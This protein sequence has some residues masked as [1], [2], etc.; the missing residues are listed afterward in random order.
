MAFDPFSSGRATPV[1]VQQPAD[2]VKEFD[3]FASGTAIETKPNYET[4]KQDTFYALD[5]DK[6]AYA[7]KTASYYGNL[8]DVENRLDNDK[9]KAMQSLIASAPVD[10]KREYTARSINQWFVGSQMPDMDP[11]WISDNWEGAKQAFAKTRL[12][13]D[14]EKI[15]DETLY[16]SVSR[17]LKEGTLDPKKPFRWHVP[18]EIFPLQDAE[19]AAHQSFWDSINNANIKLDRAPNNLPDVE[20]PYGPLG[21]PAVVAAI[22]NGAVAPFIE[23]L[24]SPIG[25]LTLGVVPELKLA[26]K[27]SVLAKSALLSLE[28][29]FTAMMGHATYNNVKEFKKL[30]DNPNSTTQDII[31]KGSELFLSSAGTIAAPL[32]L[33]FESLGSKADSI[34]AEMADKKPSAAADVLRKEAATAKDPA[35][36]ASVDNAAQSLED[37]SKFENGPASWPVAQEVPQAEFDFPDVTEEARNQVPTEPVIAPV[38]AYNETSLKNAV[39]ELERA[40]ETGEGFTETEKRVMAPQWIKSG[41]ILEK[42]PEAGEEL[43]ARL[44]KDP[45]IGLSDIQSAILLRYKLDIEAKKTK[46][47]DLFND[48]SQPA[49]VREAAFTRLQ[50]AIAEKVQ[51]LD[52][53]KAR[54]SEWGR[55]G[56]WRQAV[57]KEDYSFS[58]QSALLQ[59][60]KGGVEL[61]ESEITDLSEKVKKV[62][63]A[64]NQ[65]KSHLNNK[66]DFKPN[67]A[68]DDLIKE[69]EGSS[70]KPIQFKKAER[71]QE[72]LKAKA[73]ESRKYLNGKLFSASPE[74]IYHLGVIGAEHIYTSGLDFAKWS[75]EMVRDL[76]EKVTPYLNQI[77]DESKKEFH[78]QHRETIIDDLKSAIADDD[79][80]EIGSIAQQLAK[81]F[82]SDGLKTR[83]AIVN[84]VQKEL[85]KTIPDITERETRDSIS[86]Y[87]KYR[88]LTQ[89]ELSVK[90][91]DVKGQLQQISKLE[92]IASGEGVK[93]T[94]LERR[95]PS[96]EEKEL[97]G[98]VK[99]ALKPKKPYQEIALERIKSRLQNDIDSLEKQIATKTKEAKVKQSVILDSEAEELKEKRTEL[100]KQYKEVFDD[101]ELNA[102]QRLNRFKSRQNAL[103]LKYEE[104]LRNN[105]YAPNPKPVPI[106]LDNEAIKLKQNVERLKQDIGTAREKARLEAR[107]KYVKTLESVTSIARMGAI[108]GVDTLAKLA[109]FSL[110]KIIETPLAEGA[111]VLLKAVPYLKEDIL[112]KATSESGNEFKSLGQ[113]YSKGAIEGAKEAWSTLKTGKGILESELGET[114]ANVRPL[115]WYDYVGT[116]HKVE[117][118]FVR[119]GDYYLRESRRF[120][121]AAAEGKD[122][123]SELVQGAIRKESYNEAARSI[124]QENN[125][126]ANAVNQLAGDT[127]AANQ[128]FKDPNISKTVLSTFIKTFVTKGIVKTPLNFIKQTIERSPYGLAESGLRIG[129]AYMNGIENLKTEEANTIVRLLK[130]GA[131]GS[132]MFV[133]GAI[134]AYQDPDKRMFGGYYTPGKR[135]SNDVSFGKCRIDG[136]ELPHVL[137]HNLLTE[138]AQMGST[139]IRVMSSKMSKKDAEDQGVIA[140]FVASLWGLLDQGAPY[141]TPI[142]RTAQAAGRGQ[143]QK[144]VNDEIAGL[145]PRFVTN[146]AEYLDKR[147]GVKVK[148]KPSNVIQAVETTIPIV[149]Q[150]VPEDVKTK[151]DVGKRFKAI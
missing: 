26:S 146:W 68:L 106:A 3:P 52:A 53:V 33:A 8:D 18:I 93:K 36:S 70:K 89:D 56:R 29:G 115:K 138:E 94:G 136:V 140:G 101:P 20:S 23:S 148:R 109:G 73:E 85:A 78:Q 130:L 132:A 37:L 54:G 12:G 27:T 66:K 125:S 10:Q 2:Q 113:Y 38:E 71:L 108:S 107:P 100:R 127:E 149:R 124:L 102:N 82:I 60:A 67:Q 76:G 4:P 9:K 63:D 151:R 145:T 64:Q 14:I 90:L 96:A 65:L 142:A 62:E 87:G 137:T 133:W 47:L 131:I 116:I 105:D 98:K 135:S 31:T 79:N 103:I 16:D 118:S 50:K 21:N 143:Y 83:D 129:R 61:T 7:N 1:G 32:S 121:N 28:A 55:E 57:A 92:D 97:I 72:V 119:T 34:A 88:Q 99:E 22:Y 25:L 46:A 30:T 17:R 45:N 49:D 19:K 134:D 69:G 59:A 144:L 77:W 110:G 117:K 39:A 40:N 75:A 123:S 44:Y 35:V 11:K 141:V 91:R 126:Y 6:K 41:E 120:A 81:G 15:S 48:N 80:V 74:V 58:A 122:L 128:D 43:A 95:K 86:G 84:A 139:F 51:L 111:G 150:T 24:S 104:K 42:N 114:R 5:E 112:K 147:D 13:L